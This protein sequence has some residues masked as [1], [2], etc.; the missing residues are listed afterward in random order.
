M[1]RKRYVLLI[2]CFAVV[3]LATCKKQDPCDMFHHVSADFII[4]EDVNFVSNWEPYPTD[5]VALSS[6]RFTAHE[7]KADRYEWH[8]GARTYD[9]KSVLID[10]ATRQSGEN[11]I[12]ITL[13][14][15]KKP[16]PECAQLDSVVSFTKNVTFVPHC[17]TLMAGSFTGYRDDNPKDTATI[18]INPCDTTNPYDKYQ[19]YVSVY[20]LT[21]KCKT[22]NT[23]LIGYRKLEV[24]ARRY[25]NDVCS[26]GAKPRGWAVLANDNRTITISYKDGESIKYV[27]RGKKN[28]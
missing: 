13:T 10:F 9:G 24:G 6:V 2:S 14:V 23:S 16:A 19:W 5:T 17:K 4:E 1:K 7:K 11:R 21:P 12:P 18:I 3:V 15:H 20:N 28:N 22:F 26:L 25:A 27:F 8:I